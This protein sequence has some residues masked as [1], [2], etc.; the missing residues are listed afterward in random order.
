M[1]NNNDHYH[2]SVYVYNYMAL[3]AGGG[4]DDSEYAWCMIMTKS[5]GIMMMY[6][7]KTA[8]QTHHNNTI[9]MK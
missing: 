1:Y 3:T 8:A 9:I 2:A 6:N 4:C 7:I 5:V